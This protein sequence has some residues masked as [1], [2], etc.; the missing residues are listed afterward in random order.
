MAVYYIPTDYAGGTILVNEGDIF[1]FESGA[2]TNV[3]FESASGLPTDFSIQFTESNPNA[4]T[5]EVKNDLSADITIADDVSLDNLYIK[6]PNSDSTNV[7]IG[8]NVTLDRFDGSNNGT[9]TVVVGDNFTTNNDFRTNGGDDSVT[10]GNN[11]TAPKFDTG[12]GNDTLVT[13]DPN[14]TVA[15]AENVD[16]IGEGTTTYF[17]PTDFAGGTILVNEGD[18][19]VFEPGASTDVTFT[20]ASGLPVEFGVEFTETNTNPFAVTVNDGM[21]VDITIADGVSLGGVAID[22]RNAGSTD[23]TIGD[24]VTLQKFDGSNTGSDTVVIGDNF[25]TTND[26]KTNGG[27][28]TVTVGENFT[29]TKIDTGNE[30]DTVITRDPNATI[31]NAETIIEPDGVV[32]GTAGDDTI[33]AGYSDIETD[34][35]DGDDGL[36]DIIVGYYGNDTISGG[37]GND[38]IYGDYAE[39]YTPPPDPAPGAE[40]LTFVIDDTAASGGSV[41]ISVTTIGGTKDLPND[42][43]ITDSSSVPVSSVHVRA[44][45]NGGDEDVVRFDLTTFDDDFTITLQSEAAEDKIVLIGVETT[46]DNGD[47]SFTYTYV[48]SDGQTHSVTAVPG[49]AS[50]ETYQ[51][52]L[53]ASVSSDAI[54][55][56]AGDDTIYGGFGDDQIT[57]GTGSDTIDGG[58]GDDTIDGGDDADVLIGGAGNDTI[59]GGAG[60]DTLAGDDP[61][62]AAT[63]DR[64]ALQWSNVADPDDGGQ[65]DNLDA[66]VSGSQEVGGV[67]VDFSVTGNAGQYETTTVFTD[68]I[69]AGSGS[70]DTNSALGL[71]GSNGVVT[72]DFSTSVENVQF[73]LNDFE[74]NSETVTIRAYDAN[75]NL[76]T[77]TVTEGSGITGTDTDGVA[78]NDTF[79]GPLSNTGDNSS[80]GSILVEIPGPVARIEVDYTQTNGSLT[81]TDVYFDEPVPSGENSGDDNID[82]GAGDDVIIASR[83]T[84]TVDGG[85]GRD[86]YDASGSGSLVDDTIS[87]NVD[88]AGDGTVKKTGDG[89]TD[90]VT[91]VESFIADEVDGQIDAITLTGTI[92][93]NTISGLSDDAVGFFTPASGGAPIAFG[94]PGEPT[95]N[96]LLSG[97]YDPGTGVIQPKGTYEI[98]SGE[99]DG[100]QVGTISFS[101]FEEAT[102]SVVCYAPG[103]LIDTP[104]GPKEVQNLRPGDEVVT[105]DAGPQSVRWV[106]Q[107]DQALDGV[108]PEKRPVLI[109]AGA[110]G[111]GPDHDLVVSPQHRI[112]VGG[113]GQ[114]EA[115]FP[116]ECF[117]PAKSLVGLPGV[118]HLNDRQEITWV[119]FALDRHHVVH[120]NG[121]L[122]ESLLLGPMV[123]AGLTLEERRRVLEIF[124]PA[125]RDGSALN[126]PPARECLSVRAAARRILCLGTGK[127]SEMRAAG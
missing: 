93:R 66:I 38:T 3:A 115:A 68:G 100:A 42:L 98:T 65:I 49:A 116:W 67:T 88:Q 33:G 50:V 46:T 28:D 11:A 12:G 112:L 75:N 122:S 15:N 78:G 114:L 24:D 123:I 71:D 118:R 82:G 76:I 83:G 31:S 10:I 102:F 89:T 104:S 5:V 121:L 29:G 59:L 119:H 30:T 110:L 61:A 34:A 44:I 51:T 62:V 36:D 86:T 87:V 90:T 117:A 32:D 70:V 53:D 14:I 41:D 60:N 72:I 40:E 21:N 127:Q 108:E 18:I 17:I 35:V 56:G 85:T 107:A 63:P 22:A 8:N 81:M 26:V 74:A 39:A 109:R 79:Q 124:G 92:D 13:D 96:Q 103:T 91:S 57:G 25:T 47:G 16:V 77:F 54:D 95:I 37:D 52:P 6:A 111:Q 20:S 1:V 2:S 55:G 19:F 105:L 4:I 9:D 43:L 7:T 99:E 97:T 73:R 45:G 120:A 64:A 69:D 125:P 106:R 126:G 94:G 80:V 113:R 27:D 101:N 48:G 84:D 58:V 23:V